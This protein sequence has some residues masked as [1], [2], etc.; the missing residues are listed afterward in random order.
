M[1]DRRLLQGSKQCQPL[2]RLWH[3]YFSRRHVGDLCVAAESLQ[4]QQPRLDLVDQPG[5]LTVREGCERVLNIRQS[6]AFRSARSGLGNLFQRDQRPQARQS[7]RSD[8]IAVDAEARGFVED[9]R[10]RRAC[11]RGDFLAVDTSH[12]HILF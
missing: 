12:T 10:E 1:F 9:R 4:R 5:S 8:L 2:H 7:S 11:F 3:Y 6:A